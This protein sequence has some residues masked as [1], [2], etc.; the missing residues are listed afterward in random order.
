[1]YHALA[2][3]DMLDLC[4]VTTAFADGL[5]E[6]WQ[7]LQDDWRARVPGMCAW[8]RA[9]C[10]PDQKQKTGSKKSGSD[11]DFPDFH[12][13]G[14]I[15]FFND[16]AIGIAP[17]PAELLRY[18]GALGFVDGAPRT[19]P[20]T[21]LRDSGYVRVAQG[22]AIALL[23][24][25]LV[26]PDYLPGHA[27]A[28]TLSFELSVFG[29]RVLVNSGTSCYGTSAERLRQRGTA[30][31]NTVVVD[32]QDSSEVWAG[33]RV[34]RRARP[35]GLRVETRDGIRVSCAHDGYR[36][37]PGRPEHRREWTLSAGGLMVEDWVAGGFERAEARFH[38]HPDVAVEPGA[39]SGAGCLH[40]RDGGRVRWR[41]ERGALR[42][43]PATWHPRFGSSEPTSCLVLDLH[44][45]AS[46][47][48]FDWD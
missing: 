9:M 7:G 18:A 36:R 45:G 39:D 37:L 20:V 3:E 8:L 21:H 24:V 41:V 42:I 31:H 47:I 25:A 4:N 30:A 38:V 48:R 2:L 17:A 10:H 26:G 35:R 15:G 44:D 32:G 46:R 12:P 23:D 13:D 34:A 5:P 27:H 40:L 1:M 11:P 28:D 14:E 43:V 33:F 29:Q 19:G 6:R 22:P 16:A